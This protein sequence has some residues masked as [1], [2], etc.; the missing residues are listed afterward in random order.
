MRGND[1]SRTTSEHFI[2]S[3]LDRFAGRPSLLH[4]DAYREQ[5]GYRYAET[6][7]QERSE[8]YGDFGTD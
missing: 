8:L 6:A 1:R 5:F 4:T 3:P 7:C 2:F